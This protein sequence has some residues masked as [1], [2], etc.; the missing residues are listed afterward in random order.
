MIESK[1]QSS[2]LYGECDLVDKSPGHGI[3]APPQPLSFTEELLKKTKEQRCQLDQDSKET[4]GTNEL[5]ANNQ[6]QSGLGSSDKPTE[7]GKGDEKAHIGGYD[8]QPTPKQLATEK[9]NLIATKEVDSK[10]IEMNMTQPEIT[11]TVIDTSDSSITAAIGRHLVNIC[12]DQ[13]FVYFNKLSILLS[14]Q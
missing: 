3:D 13:L 9:K 5:E 14:W 12:C 4:V 10:K 2:D 1:M 11:V 6:V 8:K 7:S